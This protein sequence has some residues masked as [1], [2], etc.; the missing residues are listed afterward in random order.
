MRESFNEEVP[1]SEYGRWKR[2]QFLARGQLHA[3]MADRAALEAHGQSEDHH[4]VQAGQGGMYQHMTPQER[5]AA[6]AARQATVGSEYGGRP[7]ER[8]GGTF[9]HAN[10]GPVPGRAD[11]RF[12]NQPGG[13]PAA[14]AV[15][16]TVAYMRSRDQ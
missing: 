14:D 9:D 7:L 13:P 5:G 10:D 1:V 11:L 3:E 12:V 15:S 4:R 16:P 8:L 2:E 6:V